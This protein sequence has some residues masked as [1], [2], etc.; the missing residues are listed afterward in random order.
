MPVHSVSVPIDTPHVC[1]ICHNSAGW[2]FRVCQCAGTMGWY[3]RHCLVKYLAVTPDPTTCSI[4]RTPYHLPRMW[5][6]FPW[7]LR[8]LMIPVW[9]VTDASLFP[10]IIVTGLV[11]VCAMLLLR[12]F[13]EIMDWLDKGRTRGIAFRRRIETYIDETY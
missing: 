4:C 11:M 10:F 5:P 3:H 7:I 2:L 6:Y 13:F 1:I 9:L 12:I 8:V